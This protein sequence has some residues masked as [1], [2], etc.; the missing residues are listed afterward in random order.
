[1]QPPPHRQCFTLVDRE[2]Y[3]AL[4][5]NTYTGLVVG[6]QSICWYQ[7]QQYETKSVFIDDH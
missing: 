1:M 4:Y 7:S 5:L 3:I 6:W 2:F